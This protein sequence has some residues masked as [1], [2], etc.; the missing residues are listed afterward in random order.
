MS[1][2]CRWTVWNANS[3]DFYFWARRPDR[4]RNRHHTFRLNPAEH[5]VPVRKLI[6]STT[7]P[8]PKSLREW[9]VS[10]EFF[11][12]KHH[13]S[14]FREASAHQ[15]W[16]CL[17]SFDVLYS[18]CSVGACCL[19]HCRLQTSL[20]LMTDKQ[21]YTCKSEMLRDLHRYRLRKQNCPSCNF[22]WCENLKDSDMTL[23]K[24]RA[25][26]RAR[27]SEFQIAARLSLLSHCRLTLSGSTETRN[28]SS[29][30][31][32]CWPNW[33]WTRL[34][35]SPRVKRTLQTKGWSRS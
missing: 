32:V 35:R 29:G 26:N 28:P 8:S 22:S 6:R 18:S 24:V 33:R 15:P 23:R 20:F 25:H 1:V 27:N 19:D 21:T 7:S 16:T 2:L 11:Q 9:K 12:I 10:P 13:C 4:S 17:S 3:T 5:H 31:L 30:L 34:T 14:V